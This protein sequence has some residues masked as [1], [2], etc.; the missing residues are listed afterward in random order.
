MGAPLPSPLPP[1][2]DDDLAYVSLPASGD[3]GFPQAFLLQI[4]GVIYRLTLSVYYPDPDLILNTAYAGIVF[5][6]P[7]RSMA[8]T[9]TCAPSSR[10][11]RRR[12]A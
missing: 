4:Q 6:L 1:W 12:R 10:T 9:S 11:S 5:D 7:T 8:F 2:P 3:D